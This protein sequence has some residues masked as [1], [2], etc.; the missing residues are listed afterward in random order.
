MFNYGVR[1]IFSCQAAGPE[2]GMDI[3]VKDII[4][5]FGRLKMIRELPAD[6]NR[7]Y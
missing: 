3:L 7:S 4:A 1:I 5:L 6:I 2:G